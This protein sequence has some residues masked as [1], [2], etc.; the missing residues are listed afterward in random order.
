[1]SVN[2]TTS[3][4]GHLAKYLELPQPAHLVQ[5]EYVWVDGDGGLRCK[6]TVSTNSKLLTTQEFRDDVLN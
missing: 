5:A 3:A 2:P 4:P 6:T 1:M